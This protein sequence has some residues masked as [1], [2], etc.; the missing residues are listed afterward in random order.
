MKINTFTLIL[1]IA[2]AGIIS[3]FI[4]IYVFGE[5]KWILGIGS[6][7]TLAISLVG[8]VSLSFDYERTTSLTRITSGVFFV[9][10]LISQIIFTAINKFLLPTYVMVTGGL[11]ILYALIVYSISKSKH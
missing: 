5:N 9:V 7:L 1:S 4:S 8:T 2:L 10:L 11:T 6:F 3:F